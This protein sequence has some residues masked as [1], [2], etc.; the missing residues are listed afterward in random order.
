MICPSCGNEIRSNEVFCGQCGAPITPSSKPTEMVQ[1][2]PRRSGLLSNGYQTQQAPLPAESYAPTGQSPAPLYGNQPPDAS[3]LRPQTPQGPQQQ[4]GFYQD[5]TEAMS[6]LPN[7]GQN[8]PMPQQGY[9]GAPMQ[10]SYPATSYGHPTAPFQSGIGQSYPPTYPTPFQTGPGAGPHITPPPRKQRNGAV[11]V[12]AIICLVFAIIAA[13]AFG[14]LY[15]TRARNQTVANTTPTTAPTTIP[16][17]SPTVIPSPSPTPSP[18]PSP[19]PSPSPTATPDT[20]FNF[21]DTNCVQNHFNVEYPATWQ[22]SAPD[23]T[24]NVFSNPSQTDTYAIFRTP[25]QASSTA[26]ALLNADLTANYSTKT[27]Y[28]PPQSTSNTTIGGENWVYAVATYQNNG[29][30]EQIEV[31][32][33]VH[34][35]N[36]FIIELQAPTTQFSTVNSTAFEPMLNRFSFQ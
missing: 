29:V 35:G 12:I 3:T 31:F 7:S 13:S 25:G 8:Y 23:A 30:P 9:P 36:A 28:T 20:G 5:A 32:A 15:V 14:V 17:P 1:T 10:G 4:S 26:D 2:P 19:S 18:T 33:T 21:C 6:A 34:Q 22:P 11:L 27:S 16:S 24:T